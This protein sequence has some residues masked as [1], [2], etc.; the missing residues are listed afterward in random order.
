MQY[1]RLIYIRFDKEILVG[2]RA[3]LY[4]LTCDK[5]SFGT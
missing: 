2:T 4:N 3:K 5:I 1:I